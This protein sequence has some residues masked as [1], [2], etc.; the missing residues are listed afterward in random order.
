M[1]LVIWSTGIDL[2]FNFSCAAKAATILSLSL[3]FSFS[4]ISHGQANQ[5]ARDFKK[6]FQTFAKST[7]GQKGNWLDKTS[8][9]ASY[10][11]SINTLERTKD[12]KNGSEK[13]AAKKF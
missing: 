8:P 13:A 1:I 12:Q 6:E 11:N 3:C 9:W 10:F 4:N 2:L 5:S 7:Q